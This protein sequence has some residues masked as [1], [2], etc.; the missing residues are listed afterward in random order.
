M[1]DRKGGKKFEGMREMIERYGHPVTGATG[2]LFNKGST[3][4][5]PL[6]GCAVAHFTPRIERY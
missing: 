2:K 5:S 6:E 4:P 3:R 1:I